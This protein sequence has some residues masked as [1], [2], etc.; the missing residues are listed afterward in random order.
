MTLYHVLNRGVEG[1]SLFVDSSDHARFVHDLYVFND[2]APAPEFERRSGLSSDVGCRTSHIR[3]KLVEVHGWALVRNHY[4]LIL[5]GLVEDGI[6]LFLKK[7]NGGYSHYFNERYGRKGSL[8][9]GKTK[10]IPIETDAQ[11]LYILH[12]V[13]FNGLD[14][15]P[16]A[17]DWRLRDKGSIRNAEEALRHLESYRWSSYLDYIGKRNFPS[18]ITTRLFDE[19]YGGYAR[20]AKEFLASG[21]DE[22]L[23]A[24]RLE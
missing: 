23:V 7:L 14:L 1:R 6:P 15:F 20:A 21:E 18:V 10:K 22:S 16:A 9:Q 4:H 8:F 24:L 19:A 3:K 17:K 2:V 12:Y 13:H 11:F 5:E